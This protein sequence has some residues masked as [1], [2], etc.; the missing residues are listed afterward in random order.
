MQKSDTLVNGR[1]TQVIWIEIERS[2][3]DI[4]I[5]INQIIQN[6]RIGLVFTREL[7]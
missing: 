3:L 2:Q 6:W 5:G 4:E 7:G 1:L